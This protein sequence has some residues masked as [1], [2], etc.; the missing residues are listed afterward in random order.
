M[1]GA[2]RLRMKIWGNYARKLTSR[3]CLRGLSDL[4]LLRSLLAKF[5]DRFHTVGHEIALNVKYL[6]GI[7]ER[8]DGG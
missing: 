5:Q 4:S 6:C 2:E 8:G 7:D 1:K 3:E